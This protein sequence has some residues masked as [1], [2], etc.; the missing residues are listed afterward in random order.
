MKLWN[1]HRNVLLKTYHVHA[2]EVLDA[3]S[4]SDNSQICSCGMDKYVCLTDVATGKS[5]RKYRG[6]AGIVNCVKYNEESSVILSGSTDNSVRIWDCKSR[7]LEPVQVPY[8]VKHR[9]FY[10]YLF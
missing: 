9:I 8:I 6:H 10:L 3:Q 1:P 7:K 5:L 4:S 2:Y